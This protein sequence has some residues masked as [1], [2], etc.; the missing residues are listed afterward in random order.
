MLKIEVFKEDVI[1]TPRTMPGKDGKPPRTI[2]EQ[3][4]YA[5]L[6]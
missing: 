6:Q 5:H 3:D 2:Y 4:A 1:V